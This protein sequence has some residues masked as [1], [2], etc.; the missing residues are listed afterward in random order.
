MKQF[1]SLVCSTLLS[2]TA[3]RAAFQ[4]PDQCNGNVQVRPEWYSLGDDLKQ[5]FVD[6]I[7][8]LHESGEYE[9]FAQRHF[10]YKD[11]VHNNDG[12]GMFHRCFLL[13]FEKSL[14]NCYKKKYPTRNIVVC[15]YVM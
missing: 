9:K 1:F 12:F 6:G 8:C 13:D 3:V 10:E 14:K 15:S 2:L 4:I 7:L 5:A 11:K